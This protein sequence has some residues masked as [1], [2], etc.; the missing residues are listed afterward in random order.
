V[1][2]PKEPSFTLI[3]DTREQ[4]PFQFKGLNMVRGTLKAGDYSLVGYT[5]KVAVERKSHEDAWGCV[6]TGRERFER[7]L[8]RLAALDR[9]AVVIECNL[10]Q[11]AERPEYVRRVT[12][13]TAVGSYISWAC[14][15]RI[16][17]F[18]CDSRAYAERV[19]VRFLVAYLKHLANGGV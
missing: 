19:T 4:H 7:C 3:V 6:A 11:F 12:P 10:R 14:Q 1:P 5:G 8:E 2:K 9:A 15:Y 17:V 16:P 13:A 18:F